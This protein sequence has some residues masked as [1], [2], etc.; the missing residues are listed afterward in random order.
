M[1]FYFLDD[2]IPRQDTDPNIESEC[3]DGTLDNTTSDTSF[4]YITSHRR[5]STPRCDKIVPGSICRGEQLEDEEQ[6]EDIESKFEDS[7]N[8]Y[9][10]DIK[11]KT[12]G[13][14]AQDNNTTSDI[15]TITT[16]RRSSTPHCER[17]VPGAIGRGEQLTDDEEP[18]IDFEN[19]SSKNDSKSNTAIVLSD[20]NYY[21]QEACK[22]EVVPVV[23]VENNNEDQKFA[24]SDNDCIKNTENKSSLQNKDE[25]LKTTAIT[26]SKLDERI[27]PGAISRGDNPEVAKIADA[28]TLEQ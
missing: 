14:I 19:K 27:V 6:H 23:K 16:Q 21:K 22:I 25:C 7:V 26:L 8:D 10:Q 20:H 18:Y 13:D 24:D 2:H 28:T 3:D 9:K 15:V 5:S 1:F 12:K 17:I 11:S 4:S